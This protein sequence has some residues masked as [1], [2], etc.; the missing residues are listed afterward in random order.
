MEGMPASAA[1]V[2]AFTVPENGSWTKTLVPTLIPETA[3][4]GAEP[5]HSWG[6]KVSMPYFMEV[7]G[8]ELTQLR[9]GREAL[10]PVR[11][12]S[13]MQE[14]YWHAS[15]RGVGGESLAPVPD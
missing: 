6:P 3:R 12:P 1:K 9:S 15:L 5:F 7:T 10:W 8:K 14:L 2:A 13:G 11:L 4:S